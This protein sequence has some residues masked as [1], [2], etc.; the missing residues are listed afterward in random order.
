VSYKGVREWIEKVNELGELKV[1]E[2]AD[3]NLET[4]ALSV[5][6]SK[7]KEWSPALLSDCIKDYPAGYRILVGFF[8]SLRRSTLTT[9]LP[10]DISAKDSY[11]HGATDSARGPRSLP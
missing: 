4:G 8:E 1:I 11:R 3:W 10:I 6:A 5:L 9:K 2:G 7:H